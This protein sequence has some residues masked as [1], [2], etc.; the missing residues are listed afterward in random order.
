MTFFSLTFPINI[1]SINFAQLIVNLENNIM[2]LDFASKFNNM[3]L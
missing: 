2:E 1:P 3:T